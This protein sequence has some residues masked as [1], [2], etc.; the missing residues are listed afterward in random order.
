[1]IQSSFD[2]PSFQNITSTRT[3]EYRI[4][5]KFSKL[6]ALKPPATLTQHEISMIAANIDQNKPI[7][8]NRV[9]KQI[10]LINGQ[11]VEV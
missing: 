4:R 2:H 9:K 11:L 3:N 6:K 7:G 5:E 10:M 1:M 8:Q